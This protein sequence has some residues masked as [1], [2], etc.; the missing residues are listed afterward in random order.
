MDEIDL[1]RDKYV[2]RI[3]FRDEVSLNRFMFVMELNTFWK[4]TSSYNVF[5]GAVSVE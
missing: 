4:E 1:W 3:F 5:K 2:L